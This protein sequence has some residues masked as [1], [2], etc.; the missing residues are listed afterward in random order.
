MEF[1]VEGIR[2]TT[3]AAKLAILDT[4]KASTHGRDHKINLLG[5]PSQPGN[6]EVRRG[7]R[8]T[9]N[10]RARFASAFDELKR[11]DLI[12]ADYGDITDPE[13][14][15]DI[16]ERGKRALERMALDDLDEALA[17]VNPNLCDLRE[18]AWS[19]LES[20]SADGLRQAADSMRELVDQV[21]QFLAPIEEV[22]RAKWFVRDESSDTGVTRA[23]RARLAMEKR[24]G[25]ACDATCEQLSASV[26]RLSKLKH[27][28]VVLEKPVVENAIASAEL[29]LGALFSRPVGEEGA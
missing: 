27:S 7:W 21:L 15:V 4:L 22:R 1:S 13:H 18:G 8:F 9:P 14:W 19:R 26:R 12:R 2:W 11:D 24:W 5:R 23:H 29:S 28:R 3:R 20:G 10:E 16:T 25:S 6:L 17:R